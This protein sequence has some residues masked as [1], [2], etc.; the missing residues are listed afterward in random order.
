MTCTWDPQYKR[1]AI[2][3]PGED[4]YFRNY[5]TVVTPVGDPVLTP[6]VDSVDG[7]LLVE[8]RNQQGNSV[9]GMFQF[10][11]YRI[12][13]QPLRPIVALGNVMADG[14]LDRANPS[15]VTCTWD[16]QYKRYA[17]TIPGEDYYFRNYV[18]VVTPVGDPV[19]TPAVDSVDGKLLVELRN[20]Q[21]NSVPGMFQF[22]TYRII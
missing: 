15:N 9:P 21:G 11:T 18:T 3:I 1:Y 10:V 7:K 19:L 4:Y 17:I 6:A 8:L 12:I 14:E 2:T 13:A 22:V 5:V 20:Q 16:P